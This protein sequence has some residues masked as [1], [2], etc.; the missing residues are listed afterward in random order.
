VILSSL[1]AGK[2]MAFGAFHNKTV[3]GIS[4]IHLLEKPAAVFLVYLSLIPEYRGNGIGPAFLDYIFTAGQTALSDKG[5]QSIGNVWE[6]ERPSEALTAAEK[7]GRE[8]RIHFFERNHA[9]RL[10]VNY[11]QPPVDG[12]T[13]VP[14]HLM[15]RSTADQVDDTD[16]QISLARAIYFEKY[17]ETNKI[18]HE[19]LNRLFESL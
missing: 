6:V 7:I 12:S 1:L 15:L 9:R 4:T 10:S 3:V 8:K 16:F 5:Y 17:E 14:M 13:C 18:P 19:I 11:I 2:G